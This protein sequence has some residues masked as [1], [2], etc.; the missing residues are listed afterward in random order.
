MYAPFLQIFR[1]KNAWLGLL[2]CFA[3]L[4]HAL[5]SGDF[6]YE[7]INGGTEVEITD[8]TGAGGNVEIPATID[9]KAFKP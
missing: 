4:A 8:Y 6:G 1:F 2:V 5:S 3:P 9:S 7:L